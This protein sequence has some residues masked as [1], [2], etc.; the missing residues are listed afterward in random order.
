[1]ASGGLDNFQITTWYK[2]VIAASV[3]VLIAALAA[4]RPNV[5]MV[6]LGGFLFGIGQWIN[7]PKRIGFAPGYKIT[8]TSREA[9]APGLFLEGVGIL[10]IAWGAY[11]LLYLGL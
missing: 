11:R 4:G 3:L 9:S 1:M 2:A 7:H 10:L 8:K 6:A 5:A